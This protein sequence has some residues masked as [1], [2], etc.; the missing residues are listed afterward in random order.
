MTALLSS[1]IL[2]GKFFFTNEEDKSAIDWSIYSTYVL[3][4]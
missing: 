1:V 4:C 3:Y 2:F